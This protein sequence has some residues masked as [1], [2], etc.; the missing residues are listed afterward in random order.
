M[1]YALSVGKYIGLNFFMD[2]L[3]LS[4]LIVMGG[5]IVLIGLLEVIEL[6]DLEFMN[7]LSNILF[8]I[9]LIGVLVGLLIMVDIIWDGVIFPFLT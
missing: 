4:I 8:V 7:T 9:A 5:I 6:C 1:V 2:S 3:F